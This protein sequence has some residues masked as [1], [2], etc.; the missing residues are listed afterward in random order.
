[1]IGIALVPIIF[2]AVFFLYPVG[3]LIKRGLMPQGHLDFEPL[4]RA[5]GSTGTGQVVWFTVWSAGL[6]TI[7]AVVLGLPV[8]YALYRLSFPGRNLLR[9][10]VTLPFVLPTVVVGL[11]FTQLFDG[12]WLAGLGL[13]GSAT[14]IVIALVYFNLGV[15]V[16]TVGRFWQDLD[17]RL[18]QAAAALGASPM[19]VWLTITLRS[20]LPAIAAAASVVFLFCA[21]A[22][23]VVLML[24]GLRYSNLETEIYYLTTE[25]FDLPSATALSLLQLLAIVVLLLVVGRIKPRRLVRVPAVPRRPQKRDAALLLLSAAIAAAVLLPIVSLGIGSA[26]RNGHWSLYYFHALAGTG[27]EPGGGS[28]LLISPWDALGNSLQIALTASAMALVLG[29]LVSYVVTRPRAGRRFS[30]PAM[31]DGIFMLPLGVSA[32]TLGFGF[33][34]TLDRAPLDLRGS[35]WLIPI[36]QAL[37][38]LP[39]VVRTVAP[40]WRSVDDRQRQAAAT[41]GANNGRVLLS[42]D[43]AVVRRAFLTAAGFALAVSMGEFGA[44]SFLAR[45]DAPTLPVV[46]YK[47]LSRPGT[48]NFGMAIAAATILAAVSAGL[49]MTFE[50]LGDRN[51]HESRGGVW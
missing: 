12:G 9:A 3:A 31:L 26:R 6:A 46:I 32:V 38:A 41:L 49:M 13:N 4:C 21:T 16:R 17:P 39:L 42:V 50:R 18:G 20:L 33:L 36:A 44:T 14:A 28:A 47:L 34:I 19:R 23:G 2:L 10:I 15:V 22:F 27:A 45:D 30:L 37:V 5:W 25:Q 35:F 48:D 29:L 8:A 11:A 43:L 40:V 1:M 7:I 51:V 24:G